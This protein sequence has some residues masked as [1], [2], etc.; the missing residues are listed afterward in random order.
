MDCRHGS[1]LQ[2]S[3]LA[4]LVCELFV[5]LQAVQRTSDTSFH[6]PLSQAELADVLG[7]STV[8]MNRMMSALRKIGV[9]TWANH[10]ITILDWE[11]LQRITEFDPTYLSLRREPR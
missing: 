8:H 7:I 5:R 2:N 10:I 9:I 1:P 11:K 4:H 3:H 6:L